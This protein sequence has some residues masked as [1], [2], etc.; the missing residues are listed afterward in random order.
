[1][2]PQP[3]R[4][5]GVVI[6][7]GLSL[8]ATGCTNTT[9][10]DRVEPTFIMVS[11]L[12]GEVGSA[13]APLPFSSEPTTR[14]MRVELLDIQQQPWTMTGDLTVEIKPGNLTVS[15]WVPIDGSTLEADVTFKNG[16]GPTRVWFSDLG[17]KDIDSGRKASFATGVSEPIWFTIPTLSELNRTDDH[18]TNQLAQQFTEVRCLDRE[19]RVTT[20]GTDGF[21]VTDMADPEGSYN[22]MFIYTFNRPDEDSAETGKR[23]IYV[24]RRLTLLTGSNQEYLATT[25]LSFPTYEVSDEAEITM[26]DPA[27]LPSAACGDND[28]L[29]GFEGGLVRV[30]DATVPTSFKSGTEEYDDYLAYGQWPI[31]LSTGCTLYVE[32]GAVPE[33]TP[34]GGDAL[35]L[36]QGTLSE[37]WG[38]WIIQPRDATDLNLTPSGPPGRLSRLPAR[39]KSP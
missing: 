11:V 23:G 20:V 17:D 9:T 4:R 19:V 6:G 8:V 38:K 7:L 14:R 39:P 21:W 25:Q 3:P 15:P 24:G 5:V 13:E 34:R 29:E 2:S 37:V 12:D 1:M 16:F 35:G 22:S 28:A 32:S 36:V 18:E 10:R 33:Y 26:P 31:T 27:L 30:E